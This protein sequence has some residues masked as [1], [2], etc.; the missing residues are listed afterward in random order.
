METKLIS[1]VAFGIPDTSISSSLAH[2]PSAL[3]FQCRSPLRNLHF[4]PV[5]QN[6]LVSLG[7]CIGH[8]L[9][10]CFRFSGKLEKIAY[11]QAFGKVKH[12]L[13]I[14]TKI[15][16][17][18]EMLKQQ[19][20]HDTPKYSAAIDLKCDN[21]PNQQGLTWPTPTVCHVLPVLH[22]TLQ[23]QTGNKKTEQNRTYGTQP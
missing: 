13:H 12:P 3:E 14:N 9:T 17:V 22:N 2:G 16:S 20:M 23:N 8:K 21:E 7:I 4:T 5:N 19:Q 6:L 1:P 15:C 11:D 18:F 10:I